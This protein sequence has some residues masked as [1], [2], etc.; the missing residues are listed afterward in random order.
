MI[1]TPYTFASTANVVE[2]VGAKPVFVDVSDI[3]LNI[4]VGQIES[5]ISG[6]TRAIICVH[7]AGLPC[8][9]DKLRRLC[10]A[11]N[12][13]LIEDAAH[14]LGATFNGAPIGRDSEY[15]A[16]SFYPTKNVTAIEGGLLLT[17]SQ[18][19][20]SMARTLRWYGLS[21]APWDRS[22]TGYMQGTEVIHPGWKYNMNDVQAA[23]GIV[24]LKKLVSVTARRRHLSSLYQSLLAN[25]DEIVTPLLGDEVRSS[26]CHLYVMRLVSSKTSLTRLEL[27]DHLA[28]RGIGTSHHYKPLHLHKY[29]REKYGFQ[30]ND[31]PIATGASESAISLPL[32]PEMTEHDVRR[33]VL[34]IKSALASH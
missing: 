33:V 9:L 26:A 27:A 15:A 34:E 7:F 2:L 10:V 20:A 21:D 23:I 28:N 5:K 18:Q 19:S 25:I 4:D 17:N 32:F 16:F 30:P 22:E 12:I 14:A 29:Y 31:F 1:T 6:R 8:D 24:Q 11:R 3:D 13:V